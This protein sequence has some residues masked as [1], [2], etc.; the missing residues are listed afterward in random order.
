VNGGTYQAGCHCA[1]CRSAN[2]SYSGRRRADWTAPTLVDAAPARAH[3][4]RLKVA[5]IGITHAEHL[6]RVSATLL[7]TVR[8]GREL[9][10]RPG[11][12]TRILAIPLKPPMNAI[13]SAVV[14]W[15]YV[16]LLR[17]EGFSDADIA[18]AIGLRRPTLELHPKRVR[19]KT[20]IRILRLY[21]ERVSEHT[22][23]DHDYEEEADERPG[24]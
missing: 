7:R 2:A 24:A 5:G 20:H 19:L 8:S 4:E 21:R 15:R 23:E 18:R 1:P 12:M 22:S 3:L 11:T 13:V 9:Q 10:I 17:K 6:S 16:R 14:T